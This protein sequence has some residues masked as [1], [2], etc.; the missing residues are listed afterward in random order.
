MATVRVEYLKVVQNDTYVNGP[1]NVISEVLAAHDSAAITGTA[2]YTGTASPTGTNAVRVTAIG[3]NAYVKTK[4]A[5]ATE[6]TATN[7]VRLVAD[8]PEV[9]AFGASRQV[10]AM[11]ATT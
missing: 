4:S 9:F 3:G 2:A 11:T 6:C 8:R 1:D 10:A 7:S 5:A